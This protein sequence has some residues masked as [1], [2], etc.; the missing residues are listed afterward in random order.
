MGPPGHFAIGFAVKPTAPAVPIWVFLIASWFL[1][2]LSFGFE[3]IGLEK[4]A[5]SQSDFEQGVSI[6]L[7]GSVPWSH[8]LVMSIIWSL[9]FGAVVYIFFRD[10]R[11]S[12]ILGFVV[13]S[14][15]VLDFIV[16]IPDLPLLLEGSPLLGLGL[17]SSG[18]GLIASTF[19]ELALIAGGIAIYIAWRKQKKTETNDRLSAI[20]DQG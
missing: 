11:T 17:W 16:H 3:A 10:W 5:V 6:I 14:H 20:G 9:L 18:P 15:W 1:D 12:G 7:P 19:L 8:G 4:F 2:V 13:F